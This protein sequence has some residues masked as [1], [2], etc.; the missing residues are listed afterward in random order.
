MKKLSQLLNLSV[1]P[2]EVLLNKIKTDK[3]GLIAG[4][5]EFPQL[6]AKQAREQGIE[7]VAIAFSE[8]TGKIIEK[9]VDKVYWISL[10]QLGKIIK[11]FKQENIKQAVMAGLIKHK[12]L[13]SNLKLDILAITLLA[14]LK[15]K[16]ADSILRAVADTLAKAGIELISALPL[17][18]DYLP[19][20]GLL[21]NTTLKKKEIEDIKFG[22]HIAKHIAA[23]D[24]GQ[25]VVV[26]NGAVIAVEAMEG[27]DACI[28]RS[29]KYIKSGAVVVKVIKPKQDLRFD[30]PV[31]GP[32]TITNLIRIRAGV[33]AFD[34]Q[35]TLML[36][37][38]EIIKQANQAKI[39]LVAV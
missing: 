5:G 20:Q 25:T 29:S 23:E 10:G 16:R 2:K 14:K 37:K 24:I 33:L 17:L 18:T 27:T 7:V 22:Y 13:F 6:V 36:H 8:E 26:K 31:I 30:T 39:S 4:W 28:L 34:T 12:K 3:L 9:N 19:S 32:K 1:T 21:T 11:I 35:A 38:Q 15:D